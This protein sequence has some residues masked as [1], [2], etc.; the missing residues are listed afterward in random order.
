MFDI[1]FINTAV[2]TVVYADDEQAAFE[3]KYAL[4]EGEDIGGLVVYAAEGVV[5]AVY[6]YEQFMG[7][8][9]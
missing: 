2:P 6:D 8:V 4:D 9:V 7:W 5:R 3:A 1:E